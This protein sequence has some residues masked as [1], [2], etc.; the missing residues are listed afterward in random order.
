MEWSHD[1]CLSCDR[2][3]SST[4]SGA[5]CSQSCRLADLEKASATI[6]PSSYS[7]TTSSSSHTSSGF[8]LPPALNFTNTSRYPASPATS[9]TTRS[10]I[11]MPSYS[12]PSSYE[13]GSLYS[14]PSRSSLSSLNSYGQI[15]PAA[16][17]DKVKNELREYAGSFDHI[18][19]WKRRMTVTV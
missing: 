8:Y 10:P 9:P 2:Q 4:D 17:S 5:Y 14:S 1:F 7:S 13:R 11:S 18:R 19:D 3:I 6:T 12:T 15:E 16:L